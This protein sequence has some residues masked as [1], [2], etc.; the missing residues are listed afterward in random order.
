MPVGQIDTFP[1][2][3]YVKQ[4]VPNEVYPS[5]P[6]ET[7]KAQAVAA[8]T[9]AW[10]SVYQNPDAPYHVSDW[11]NYQYMCDITAASTDEAVNATR[12]EYLA[13]EDAPIIAFFSAENSSPTKSIFYLPYIRS[14]DDPVSFGQTRFGHGW[15]MG[16]WGA[17]RWAA[18]Y[19]WSYQA[20]LRHYYSG[21]T[22]EEAADASN[23]DGPNVSLI[24]P[25]SNHYQTGNWLWLLANTSDAGGA[26]SQTTVY[27][28][29][30]LTTTRLISQAG[31]ANPGGYLLDISGWA[32]QPLL[33]GSLVITA[34]AFDA[35]GQRGVSP[36]VTIGLDR[37]DPT[38]HFSVT[39]TPTGSMG[40]GLILTTSVVATDTTSGVTQLG[41]GDA[42]W[43]LE[44]EQFSPQVGGGTLGSHI[45][46]DTEAL[47]GSALLLATGIQQAGYWYKRQENGLPGG[48]NYRAYF[49]LKISDNTIT[50]EVAS[51]NVIDVYTGSLIGLH[52]LRG[53]D[54]RQPDQYQEFQVD[55][56]YK[57]PG[58]EFRLQFNDRVDIV[59]DRLVVLNYPIPFTAHPP[60]LFTNQ[61][62]KLIDAAGNVSAD[63]VTLSV[64]TQPER[65]LYLPIVAK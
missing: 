47:N 49:R 9:Y 64:I 18:W 60:N 36:P 43:Q 2:E 3:V 52:R 32:D 22:L 40:S 13:F 28:S 31:P 26:I 38:G 44:G 58:V 39:F 63:L 48:E 10:Y 19:G 35:D 17:Q 51:L 6:P 62:L 4:V 30:P 46:S 55:F 1:F 53:I 50:H 45:I 20:I 11:V 7:L 57:L 25:W 16:Q 61:R 14:V 29:T 21:V 42:G 23:I 59:F 37:V 27:L 41:I 54:F 15:G 33:T 12:S 65:R 34:E 5:W 56:P 8:R 24:R